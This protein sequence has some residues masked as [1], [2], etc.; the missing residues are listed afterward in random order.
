MI[1]LL[2]SLAAL[3]P[4]ISWL[5]ERY[6]QRKKLDALQGIANAI[7]KAE[8]THDTSDLEHIVND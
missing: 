7:D 6:R 5:I 1:K 8:L 2:Q 4:G 3:I